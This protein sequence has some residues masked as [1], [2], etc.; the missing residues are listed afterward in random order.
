[1]IMMTYWRAAIL[2]F[3]VENPQPAAFGRET[4]DK[5]MPMFGKRIEQSGQT[6]RETKRLIHDRQA[7]RMIEN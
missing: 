1:M 2:L 7:D 3:L 5:L 6:D 4:K